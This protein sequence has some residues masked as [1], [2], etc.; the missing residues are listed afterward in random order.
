MTR[1]HEEPEEEI[2]YGAVAG[3]GLGGVGKGWFGYR[4]AKGLN[5]DTFNVG[6]LGALRFAEKRLHGIEKAKIRKV[7]NLLS[8]GVGGAGLGILTGGVAGDSMQRGDY[9]GMG[10]LAGS[11][12]LGYLGVV[13]AKKLGLGGKL[14]RRVEITEAGRKLLDASKL[15]K[16]NL[17]FRQSMVDS[18]P[19]VVG[20]GLLGLGG[21]YGGEE[22][23]D[24]LTSDKNKKRAIMREDK[25]RLE[26]GYV[27]LSHSVLAALVG[28]TVAG[29]VGAK[30]FGKRL[31]AQLPKRKEPI[32]MKRA[33]NTR[34]GHIYAGGVSAT[35]GA[36]GAGT[37]ENLFGSRRKYEDPLR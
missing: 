10:E 4:I 35:L 6:N 22:L 12:G 32:I 18:T 25:A 19:S 17:K 31:G 1:Y 8:G 15:S 27:P 36:A 7:G 14:L 13:G 5:D 30:V 23:G 34:L 28:G 20:S 16:D 24:Y 11:L 29:G 2:P 3:A 9:R 21:F 26:K 33:D 37:A